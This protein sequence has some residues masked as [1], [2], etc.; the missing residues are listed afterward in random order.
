MVKTIS[1]IIPCYR[2]AQTLPE[3]VR[4]IAD[5]YGNDTQYEYEIILINDCSPD[6]TFGAIRTLCAQNV[7]V[8]GI[9]LAKNFGQH[10]AIL[11]GLREAAGDIIVC[12]DDDGQTPPAE[13]CKLIQAVE[14]GHDVAIARYAHKKHSFFRNMG[15]R[16]NE[17]MAKAMIGK[18]K[19]LFLSSFVAMKRYIAEE[20]CA[21]TFPFPYISGMLLRTTNDIVNVDVAHQPRETGQSGYTFGKLLSLWLNGFTNFSIKPLR[22]A[23]V[24]GVVI[25]LLGFVLAIYAVVVKITTPEAPLGWAS[26]MAAITAIGGIILL[27]LGLVG[28]YIGRMFMGLNQQPQYVVREKI[29]FK[30]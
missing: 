2:S 27:M 28:E 19:E 24:L 14:E 3:V 6:A 25:A 29:N 22:V 20:V 4:E 10:S 13:A 5:Q 23:M 21:Y 16:L 7:R 9:D 30:Q 18:P 1:F 8:R 11:A 15:S 12:L 17:H 26:T